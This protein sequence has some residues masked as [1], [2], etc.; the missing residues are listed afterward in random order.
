MS[1]TQRVRSGKEQSMVARQ[2]RLEKYW[3]EAEKHNAE[4]RRR[5]KERSDRRKEEQERKFYKMLDDLDREKKLTDKIE[6][7]LDLRDSA[8][9]RDKNQLY[10]EWC[11]SVYNPIQ[12]DIQA[13]L[14]SVPTSTLEARR[15][16]A[17]AE[18]L[19]TVNRKEG[20]FRDIIIEHDYDPLKHRKNAFKY[21]RSKYD[22][23][24]PLHKDVTKISRE[25]ALIKSLN[26]DA[27]QIQHQPRESLDILLWDKL[28]S[29]PYARYANRE[30]EQRHKRPVPGATAFNGS[31]VEIDH[32]NVPKDPDLIKQQYF[33]GGKMVYDH[34]RRKDNLLYHH[35][36]PHFEKLRTH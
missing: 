15:R 20:V 24:D 35:N 12:R 25:A 36:T 1:Q 5:V 21:N 18:Y 30:T 6:E 14:N 10:K 8:A 3:E 17:F 11:K 27:K 22:K 2:H 23:I 13:Q 29:T 26:P 9:K 28:D 4:H 33:P 19:D 32:Y 34:P 31:T 7:Y 16:A